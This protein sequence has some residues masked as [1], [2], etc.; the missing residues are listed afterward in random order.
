MATWLQDLIA[1]AAVLVVAPL[2]AWI[3]KRHGRRI[4]GN[5]ALAS[6]LL[7]FGHAIDPPPEPKVEAAQPG[8]GGPQPGEPP[9]A[10]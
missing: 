4:R 6:I 2:V 1:I 9:K 8:K 5:L 7:G 3:G 10:D